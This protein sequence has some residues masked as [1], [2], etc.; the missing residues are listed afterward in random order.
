MKD[1]PELPFFIQVEDYHDFSYI[2]SAMELLNPKIWVK[3]IPTLRTE[4][5]S[6]LSQYVGIVYEGKRPT[7]KDI[8]YM[9][10]SPTLKI[11]PVRP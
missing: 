9:L 6:L 1:A 3:E 11:Y 4:G 8:E 7:E 5:M 2:Q 10:S